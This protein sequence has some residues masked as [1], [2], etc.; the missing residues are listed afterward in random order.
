VVNILRKI[1]Q[2]VRT[3]NL[4]NKWTIFLI[5]VLVVSVTS[6]VIDNRN[7]IER[8]DPQKLREV[9][10][11][12]ESEE[13]PRLGES[14][15]DED[16]FNSPY[17][18]QI[19]TSLNGYLDGTNSGI[20]EFALESETLEMPNCGLDIFDKNIYKSKFTVISAKDGTY[21][22]VIT[23]IVFIDKPDTLFEAWVY[24]IGK[25]GEDEYE[26][27]SFCQ[28]Q[29]DGVEDEN[30]FKMIAPEVIKNSVDYYL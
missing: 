19:R 23:D 22:G 11:I 5:F 16:I 3:H 15:T 2:Y 17:I 27:R 13:I 21:G 10:R 9:I 4:I 28:Y 6:V 14:P 8:L 7:K 24:K 29:F 18:R 30:L 1:K 20:D 26:L 12:L 25:E